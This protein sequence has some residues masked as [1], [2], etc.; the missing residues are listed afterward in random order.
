MTDIQ[1]E[2]QIECPFCAELILQKAK[3]C[4]HCGEIIDPALRR[5]EEAI[6]SSSS[7][8]PVYMNAGGGGGAAGGA[9]QQLRP[10]GHFIHIVLSFITL[11]FW[12]P[13]WILLYLFRNKNV[14]F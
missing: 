2:A 5:A 12:I 9:V 14:Y 13:V 3:K 6:R 8:A 11:G 10:W 7:Q 1:V 4:R